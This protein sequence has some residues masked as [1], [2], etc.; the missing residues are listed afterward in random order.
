MQQH[1]TTRRREH[2]VHLEFGRKVIPAAQARELEADAVIELSAFADDYVDVYA[3]GR[4]IAR[5]RPIV[6]DGKMGVRV[7]EALGGRIPVDGF[8]G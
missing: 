6:I 7:Q 2:S 5:G 4:L 8:A 3:D 1:D